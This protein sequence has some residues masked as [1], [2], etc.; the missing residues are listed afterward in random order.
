MPDLNA[1]QLKEVT[2]IS[3]LEANGAIAGDSFDVWNQQ[4]H[5]DAFAYAAKWGTGTAGTG[6]EVTVGFDAASHWSGTEQAM[7]TSA[8]HLW[9]AVAN[10]HFTVISDGGAGEVT[11]TRGSD[12]KA[13]GGITDLDPG[14]AGTTKLGTANVGDVSIDTSVDGFGPM[15]GN[16][17]TAGGYVW[18]TI[19]HEWGHVLGL[20]HA[21]DYD[22]GSP[23]VDFE[24]SYDNRAWSVMSYLDPRS[25]NPFFAEPDGGTRWGF[26]G[27]TALEPAYDRVPTT[28]MPLDIVAAQRIYGVATD[29]PLSGGG[30]VFG[31][32]SNVAGDIHNFFDFTVNQHPVIT[33]WDGGAHNTLD[34]SGYKDD[35]TITLT[36]G[37][38]SSVAGMTNNIAIAYGTRIETAIGG[39]GNDTVHA[40]DL[41]DV[42]MGGSGQDS[43]V[44]GTGNDHI[45]GNMATSV[46]GT[47][48]GA[49]LINVGAG[50]NY[51]NGNA[52]NDTILAGDGPNRLFGGQGDDHITAGN[53]PDSI[54]GNLGNDL[55]TVGNGRD[56]VHGGQGDDV[57]H[58]GSGNDLIFG[59]LGNDT[60]YAGA[61]HDVIS[62]GGGADLFVCLAGTSAIEEITDFSA[63]AGDLIDIGAAIS[64]GH[65][66]HD[67]GTNFSSES[68]AAQTAAG[69]IGTQAGIVAALQVGSDTYLFFNDGGV[70]N[71]VH[72]DGIVASSI[73]AGNFTLI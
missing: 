33:I 9:M 34:V 60:L 2:Y 63:S 52:G 45:Y 27:G 55:I 40:N 58:V 3:G 67:A 21:G 25:D 53:G 20:G 72:L 32:H 62:G 4:K 8:M 15:D 1:D 17:A 36:A 29:S 68:L 73:D 51:A 6:A 37:S 49:D 50:M 7:L 22:G 28:W 10:I 70:G 42:L 57:I 46:A 65:V 23:M 26:V 35:A 30:Q 11:V 12:G 38:F 41:G 71:V 5:H 18:H 59:D 48:D 24:R 31:F 19:I 54:N 69:L 56:T 16:F 43:L 44:G 47:T 14:T 13:K 66:L 39:S 61:G 64:T